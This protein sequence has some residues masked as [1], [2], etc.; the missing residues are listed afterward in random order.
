MD[1]HKLFIISSFKQ[2]H[3]CLYYS[4]YAQMTQ[5]KHALKATFHIAYEKQN[6]TKREKKKTK[7]TRNEL[8]TEKFTFLVNENVSIKELRK[9][10]N[11]IRWIE[12]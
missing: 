2:S 10:E 11:I 4:Q 5:S 7:T 12:V 8:E 9:L 3:K 1:M 6:A